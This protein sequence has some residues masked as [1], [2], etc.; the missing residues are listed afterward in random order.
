M[1]NLNAWNRPNFTQEISQNLK[2]EKNETHL[3]TAPFGS[4]HRRPILL[5]VNNE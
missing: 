1:L 3:V 4:E 2:K 5:Q